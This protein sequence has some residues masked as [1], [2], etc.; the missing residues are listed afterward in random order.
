MIDWKR[1]TK[2][3]AALA[4]QIAKRAH[5]ENPSVDT[6]DTEMDVEATHIYHPL[7][8]EKLLKADSF[9]FW[10]DINGIHRHL[11]RDTGRLGGCFS[12]RCS[13]PN[14]IEVNEDQLMN[15]EA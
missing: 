1:I 14:P 10:H 12:P 7:N 8:L 11:D 5:K 4:K 13:M 2:E 6:L 9:N 15:S 3:D